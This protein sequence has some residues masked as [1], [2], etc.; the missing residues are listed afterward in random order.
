MTPPPL[1]N[2]LENSYDLLASLIEAIYLF[3]YNVHKPSK[4]DFLVVKKKQHQI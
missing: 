4:L 3:G 1:W 2:F